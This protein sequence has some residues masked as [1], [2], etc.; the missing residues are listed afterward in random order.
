MSEPRV[1]DTLIIG[2][3]P[4]GYSLAADLAAEGQRV[5]LFERDSLGGT[6][7]N[8]GCIPTKCL[9]ASTGGDFA[10]AIAHMRETVDTLRSDVG[11]LLGNVELVKAEARF[12]GPRTIEACG[13]LY[14]APRIVIATGSKPAPLRCEGADRAIDSDALLAMDSL[15]EGPVVI[16][17]GGVIGLEF[18]SVLAGFGLEVSVVEFC[19]EV[20]PNMDSDLAKRL[21][22]RLR[23]RGIDIHVGTAVDEIRSDG[24]VVCHNRK[25]SVELP[26]RT[27]IAAVGRRPVLPE[28]LGNTAVRLTDRG[29]IDVNSETMETAEPGVYAVGDV[30]GL[31]MLAHAAEAQARRAA[32]M[33][34][35]LSVIPAV[36]FTEPEFAAVGSIE[37]ASVKVP[38]SS[39]GKA[40]AGN[41]GDGIL[42]LVYDH[43]THRLTGCHVLGAH[44]ADL[45]A[46]ATL[47]IANGLTAEA[48]A[49]TVHAHPTLS[50][51][52]RS[53]A[54]RVCAV[55]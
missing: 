12:A 4:G 35:N 3:G 21:R 46:E 51:L 11:T 54:L 53:A 6:C 29:F 13:E 30:N 20:L 45:V 44:A 50:E 28:G 42:R 52:F 19:P 32:G 27:V 48:V 7:L 33:P 26:A 10:T 17:G 43:D 55:R 49:A 5:A 8:R 1:F 37:G 39:N 15:P 41:E 25:G 24:T 2:G 40:L 36:V 14:E 23:K 16:V 31:C 22:Q 47:A 38:Y 34:V 9:C 18:A